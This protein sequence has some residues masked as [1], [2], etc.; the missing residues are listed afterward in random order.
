[1]KETGKGKKVFLFT[2]GCYQSAQVEVEAENENEAREKVN[3]KIYQGDLFF[4]E[5]QDFNVDL[6]E[7][8]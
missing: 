7:E 3:E 5:A 2:V 8:Y 6:V 4:D 1:M